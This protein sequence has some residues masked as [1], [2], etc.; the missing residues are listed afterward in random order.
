MQN[1]EVRGPH[2]R[3]R[4]S[5]FFILH[6]AFCIPGPCAE[7]SLIGQ[8]VTSRQTPFCGGAYEG[9]HFANARANSG[10]PPLAS[11]TEGVQ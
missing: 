7:T 9:T 8:L 1:A 4:D 5:D 2:P 11:E 3:G 6:S 10:F